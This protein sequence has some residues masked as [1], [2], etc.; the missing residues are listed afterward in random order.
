MKKVFT[1]VRFTAII[2]F[3]GILTQSFTPS[4]SRFFESII[5]PA[6]T[7]VSVRLNSNLNSEEVEIGNIIKLKVSD[8]IVI[9]GQVV[10]AH[11]AVAEGEI[12]NLKRLDNCATCPSEF[13]SIEITVTR[14][15][16]VDGS[17]IV[18]EPTPHLARGK[19][20]KCAVQ[21]NQGIAMQAHVL[22]NTTVRVR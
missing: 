10:V 18:V 19:C 9:N 20:P 14:I 8:Q 2:A 22:S 16:A 12:T 6:G 7:S 13:Q 11:G 1:I 3:V 17:F 4:V 15:K 21:L 5:V